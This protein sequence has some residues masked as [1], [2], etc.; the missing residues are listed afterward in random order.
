[1]ISAIVHGNELCGAIALDY[2]LQHAIRPEIGSLTIA[3]V[4]VAAYERFDPEHPRRSRYV[5]EDFNRLWSAAVLDGD[6]NSIELQRAR[7]LQPIVDSIDFLLDL[8]SMH[9]LS[10]PLIMAGA[11]T[12]GRE[13]ARQ[14]GS[15]SIVIAD[16]GHPAGIR[17]RDYAEF[18]DPNSPKNALL[19]E[20]GQHWQ[21]R[22]AS[23]A[24]DV[25]FRFLQQFRLV[26]PDLA[27]SHWLSESKST[28]TVIT[29]TEP[30]TVHTDRFRFVQPYVGL[31]VIPDAGTVIAYDG[32]RPIKTPYDHCV[33]VMPSFY[34][35]RGSTAVRLGRVVEGGLS[36]LQAV[37]F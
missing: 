4:N 35:K 31:E 36:G 29:V 12:K 9:H 17:M 20:C 25:M 18:A 7:E 27:Q 15:P 19:V 21:T 5:D 8:H 37:L 24:V 26:D 14:I 1:M 11:L 23:I 22:S 30:I 34:L 10:Q 16:A 2:L 6:R 33:L 32:D 13:L 28:Q 3:F